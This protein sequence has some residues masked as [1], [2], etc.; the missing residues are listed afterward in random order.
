MSTQ[1]PSTAPSA[2]DEREIH[3]IGHTAMFYW[4]PVWAIGY[5]MALLTYIDGS[6]LGFVPEGTEA[7][8]NWRVEVAP[9]KW[10]TREGLILPP[11]KSLPTDPD[12]NPLQPRLHIAQNK[13]IGVL[14]VTVLLLVIVIT[15]VPLRGMWSVVV[16]VTVIAL[17]IIFILSGIW[18]ILLNW[19]SLLSIHI[20]AGGYLTISTVLLALWVAST[21][22]FD[23][24]MYMI[25]TPGQVRVRLEIGGGETAY[26]T[27]GMVIKKERDDLFRHW[28]LGLGSGDLIVRTSGAHSHEFH[29]HNVLFVGQKLRQ[30][31]DMQRDRPVVRG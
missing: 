29:M 4:W 9:D 20:N 5:I 1:A 27:I 12:G 31:E 23:R 17:V 24:Q 15:N 3:I 21:F 6:R 14:Y 30:I 16:I 22:F 11:G 13:N 18:E 28:I 8:R 10:E 19:L 7:R 26:D 2:T 25:F